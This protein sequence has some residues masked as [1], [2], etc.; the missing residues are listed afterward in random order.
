MLKRGLQDN[1]PIENNSKAEIIS[2][3]LPAFYDMN[4]KS[5]N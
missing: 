2:N 3:D 5:I 4:F 1:K